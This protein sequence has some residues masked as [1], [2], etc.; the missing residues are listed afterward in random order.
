[1]EFGALV[2]QTQMHVGR[3]RPCWEPGSISHLT[4]A[5]AGR[6]WHSGALVH[7][8]YSLGR[9]IP[10]TAITVLVGPGLAALKSDTCRQGRKPLA[11]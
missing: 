7:F 2:L 1:M 8:C 4:S 3:S 5:S 11:L 10:L 9:P 6:P